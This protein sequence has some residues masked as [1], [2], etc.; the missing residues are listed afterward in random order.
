M[1]FDN[2]VLTSGTWNNV[3]LP[4]GG[5]GAQ[6][7]IWEARHSGS[8][9]GTDIDLLSRDTILFGPTEQTENP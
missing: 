7:G 1:N 5:L 3:L 8:F 4:C 6:E 9:T 2:V